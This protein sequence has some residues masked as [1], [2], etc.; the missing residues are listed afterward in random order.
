MLSLTVE[1]FITSNICCHNVLQILL[2]HLLM[3]PSVLDSLP[4][5]IIAVDKK[6]LK[7]FSAKVSK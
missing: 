5:S 2:K 7:F 4:N 3:R 1:G 6:H